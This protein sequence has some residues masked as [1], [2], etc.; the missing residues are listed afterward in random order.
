MKEFHKDFWPA[1]VVLGV[2][3]GLIVF[4]IWP[5]EFIRSK[6]WPHPCL[7]IQ[8]YATWL[9]Y[10]ECR[11]AGHSKGYCRIEIRK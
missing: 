2:A 5:A 3:I 9:R 1:Y 4:A 10:T 8:D 6:C 7:N 11:N